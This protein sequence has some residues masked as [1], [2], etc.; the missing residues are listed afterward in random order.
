MLFAQRSEIR[1]QRRS[2]RQRAVSQPGVSESADGVGLVLSLSHY[3]KLVGGGN[4]ETSGGYSGVQMNMIQ[5]PTVP[6]LQGL[7]LA[8]NAQTD[9]P[10]DLLGA[11][12]SSDPHWFLYL[13][14]QSNHSQG[15]TGEVLCIIVVIM[16]CSLKADF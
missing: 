15:I 4:L 8:A 7:S 10:G 6:V 12:S 3:G 14:T 9:N 13:G 16:N 11:S 1:A 2:Q 5:S